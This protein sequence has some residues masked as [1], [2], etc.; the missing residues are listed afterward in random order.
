MTPQVRSATVAV[1]RACT[2]AAAAHDSEGYQKALQA[3]S[4]GADRDIRI[5]EGLA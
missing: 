2:E 5:V 3:L 1:S 4:G